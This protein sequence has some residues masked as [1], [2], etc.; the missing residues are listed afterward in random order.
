MKWFT[1]T[2]KMLRNN[3]GEITN[4]PN[5]ISAQARSVQPSGMGA[6]DADANKFYGE[7]AIMHFT[8]GTASTVETSYLPAPFPGDIIGAYVVA[9]TSARVAAYTVRQGSAGTISVSSESNVTGVAGS[10]TDLTIDSA[11]VTTVDGILMSR[12]VQGTTGITVL[13]LVI[14]RTG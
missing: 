5:G 14:K 13:A 8:F 6:G 1:N 4:F 10:K 7:T 9:I 11:S 2:F 12:G 3:R